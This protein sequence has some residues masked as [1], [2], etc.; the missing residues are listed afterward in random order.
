M[1]VPP[2]NYRFYQYLEFGDYRE[3]TF[4]AALSIVQF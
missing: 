4:M 2:Y 1:L 3:K